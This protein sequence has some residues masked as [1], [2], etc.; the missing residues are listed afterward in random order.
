MEDFFRD[1]IA[2]LNGMYYVMTVNPDLLKKDK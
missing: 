2:G 1:L